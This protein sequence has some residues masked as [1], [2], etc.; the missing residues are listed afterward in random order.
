MKQECGQGSKPLEGM[1]CHMA[2]K[3]HN[4]KETGEFM[5]TSCLFCF[6]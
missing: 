4:T 6:K 5:C 3:K 1:G 2:N